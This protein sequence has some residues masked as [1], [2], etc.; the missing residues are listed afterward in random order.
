MKDAWR[1]AALLI[2]SSVLK[3][4]SKLYIADHTIN[5]SPPNTVIGIET[6]Q[7][8]T[9]CYFGAVIAALLIPSSVLKLR[10]RLEVCQLLHAIAALLIP[11]SVLK[12]IFFAYLVSSFSN[13]SPP[14]TVI[15]I[16]T[17]MIRFS[18]EGPGNCSPPNTVIGI[19]TAQYKKEFP[20]LKDCSPPNT[21]IGIETSA[22]ADGGR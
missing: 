13:C 5:C 15:G 10:T 20:W 9:R 17:S 22:P 7:R 19:E 2:P 18:K 3:P 8:R 14:N 4:A 12:Q 6:S 16:E 1:I 21:V 11:S